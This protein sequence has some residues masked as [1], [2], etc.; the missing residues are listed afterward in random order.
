VFLL[1]K[2]PQNQHCLFRKFSNKFVT[3]FS[4]ATLLLVERFFGAKI[5]TPSNKVAYE[6]TVTNLQEIS[7]FRNFRKKANYAKNKQKYVY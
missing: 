5:F 6:K 4:Y 3:V 2:R 1:L 7:I